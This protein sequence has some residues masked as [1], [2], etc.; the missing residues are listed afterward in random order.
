MIRREVVDTCIVFTRRHFCS[1]IRYALAHLIMSEEDGPIFTGNVPRTPRAIGQAS[2]WV[3]ATMHW[4]EN[5]SDPNLRP[6]LQAHSS[7]WTAE[8]ARARRKRVWLETAERE[9][10]CGCIWPRK[11]QTTLW[12]YF[13]PSQMP[14]RS[15]WNPYYR[16]QAT[17]TYIFARQRHQQALA[18]LA[19]QQ[20]NHQQA[21]A[22][23]AEIQQ[24]IAA[25]EGQ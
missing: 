6:F 15:T 1:Q 20:Q 24:A 12:E 19:E 13:V 10:N 18:E 9:S 4:Q 5:G 8:M 23:L 14:H 16:Y 3:S 17:I 2:I 22:E 21:L 25:Q 11:R 7:D